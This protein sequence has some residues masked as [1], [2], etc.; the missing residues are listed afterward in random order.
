MSVMEGSKTRTFG[1]KSAA[2]PVCGP[3]V[4]PESLSRGVEPPAPGAPPV[5]DPRIPPAPPTPAATLDERPPSVGGGS[6]DELSGLAARQ[7]RTTAPSNRMR[8]LSI[9]RGEPT[10][11]RLRA[12]AFRARPRKATLHR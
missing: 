11:F 9:I 3:P 5:L 1:P 2:A 6:F 7:A 10:A 12:E 8:G 4:S